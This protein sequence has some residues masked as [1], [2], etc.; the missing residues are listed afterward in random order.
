ML[1][2]FKFNVESTS[3]L[4]KVDEKCEHQVSDQNL[5][6]FYEYIYTTIVRLMI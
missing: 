3:G 1:F 5:E 6:L 4:E 2:Y